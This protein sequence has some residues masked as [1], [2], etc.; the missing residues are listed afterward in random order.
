MSNDASDISGTVN[1]DSPDMTT[2]NMKSIK[3]IKHLPDQKKSDVERHFMHGFSDT[4]K[5][6]CEIEGINPAVPDKDENLYGC[7]LPIDAML[8]AKIEF[9]AHL[10]TKKIS[11]ASNYST[12]SIHR[13]K[14][15]ETS[16]S[17]SVLITT[18]L[19]SHQCTHKIKANA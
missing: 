5:R 17:P 13:G 19:A 7:K 4:Y 11:K 1:T 16:K 3:K 18:R 9:N 2:V 15:N 6:E 10:A 14:W 8:S 12:K